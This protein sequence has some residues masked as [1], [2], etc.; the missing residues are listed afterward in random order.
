M[1]GNRKEKS[2]FKLELTRKEIFI[3]ALKPN[4]KTLFL[5]IL[6]LLLLV[7]T[8]IAYIRQDLRSDCF[9]VALVLIEFLFNAIAVPG[10]DS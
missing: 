1:A 10:S 3:R 9:E 7:L 2:I 6:V 8:V 4:R 5:T